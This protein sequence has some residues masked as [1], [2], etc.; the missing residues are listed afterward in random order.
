MPLRTFP[1][2]K[3]ENN[4]KYETPTHYNLFIFNRLCILFTKKVTHEQEIYLQPLVPPLYT[5]VPGSLEYQASSFENARYFYGKAYKGSVLG[6]VLI[7][8]SPNTI[9]FHW[10]PVADELP[11]PIMLPTVL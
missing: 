5:V 4:L 1:L 2:L 3:L 6:Y 11:S 8:R 9:T 7:E 10:T